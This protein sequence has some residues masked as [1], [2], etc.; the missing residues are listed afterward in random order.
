MNKLKWLKDIRAIGW[1]LDG[2]LYPPDA[3]PAGLVHKLQIQK[4]IAKNGWD[5]VKAENEFANLRQ[6]IGSSTTTMTKL[7]VD[8]TEF[9]RNLWNELPLGDYLK[10]DPKLAAMFAALKRFPH[11]MIS[12]SNMIPMIEKKLTLLGLDPAIFSVMISTDEVGVTKPDPRP[13]EL[14]FHQLNVLHPDISIDQVLYVGDRVDT[15]IV[16]ARGV[17]MRTCL[18]GSDSAEADICLKQVYD[19]AGL[20]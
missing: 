13:F 1:D 16:G 5:E 10:P 3:I 11:I 9:F 19:L 17:G 7:G 15:D 8:G 2:T 12:N 14:A 6:E 18:V 4:I 20:F